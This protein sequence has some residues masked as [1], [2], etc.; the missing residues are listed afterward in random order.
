MPKKGW[1]DI[2]LHGW[3]LIA[4]YSQNCFQNPIIFV[5]RCCLH[6]LTQGSLL[7]VK[8]RVCCQSG[9]SSGSAG[10][11]YGGERIKAL[12]ILYSSCCP[13]SNI[14]FLV[15]FFVKATCQG[16]FGSQWLPSGAPA[17]TPRGEEW[18]GKNT[19]VQQTVPCMNNP[20]LQK[21]LNSWL[22]M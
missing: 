12:L 1:W 11:S 9:G 3:L 13:H 14:L 7:R 16:H 19:S 4:I 10:G 18:R 5:P 2:W 8:W 15:G 22:L 17:V 6:G 20:S 21:L